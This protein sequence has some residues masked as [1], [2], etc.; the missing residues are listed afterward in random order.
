MQAPH[1]SA[2]LQ[3]NFLIL[4]MDDVGYGDITSFWNPHNL[5]PTT[6]FVDYMAAN[7]IR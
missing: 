7:G 3:P 2:S 6:P 4:L 5:A 1:I